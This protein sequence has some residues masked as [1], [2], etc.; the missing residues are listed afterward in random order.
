[1]IYVAFAGLLLLVLLV[2]FQRLE[3]LDKRHTIFLVLLGALVFDAVLAGRSAGVPVGVLRPRLMGQD[4][5]LPDLVIVAGLGVRML[6]PTRARYGAV[7]LAWATFIAIFVLGM[8]IGFLNDLPT[9]QVLFQGK[10]AFYAI[11]GIVLASGVDVR[12]AAESAGSLAVLLAPFVLVGVIVNVSSVQIQLRTPVQ[13]LPAVGVLSNDTITMLVVFGAVAGLAESVR[14]R[15]RGIALASSLVLMLSPVAGDQRASYL[16]LGFVGIAALLLLVGSTWR[17][18]SRISG[19]QVG[20]GVAAVVAIVSIGFLVTDAP[21]VFVAPV[22]STFSGVGNVQSADARLSLADEAI[23]QIREHPII[24]VGVGA[25]VTNEAP[26]AREE[27]TA[28]AHNLVLD[29]WMRLGIVGLIA[30]AGAVIVTASTGFSTWRKAASNGVA[31][32][33]LGSVFVVLGIVTKAMVEP[34][35]DKYRLSLSLSLAVGCVIAAW[36]TESERDTDVSIES[37]SVSS[38]HP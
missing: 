16:V 9:G 25:Q 34:A 28:A 7:G 2:W 21:G 3:A 23:A 15:P 27:T 38:E 26:A 17:R 32:I 30:F 18:R 29:L 22:E 8:M 24:G 1:M 5:R 11:G 4:F 36:A 12:R 19:V 20:L 33:A 6:S 14:Q 31:A 13:D 35:L 37:A 10:F